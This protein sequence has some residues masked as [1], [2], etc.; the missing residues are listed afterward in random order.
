MCV[1][2]TTVNPAKTAE[3]IEMPFGGTLAWTQRTLYGRHLA[4]MIE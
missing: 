4:N 1:L 3:L 2:V